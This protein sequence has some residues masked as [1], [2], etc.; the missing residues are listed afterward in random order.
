MSVFQLVPN[1][2]VKD[3]PVSMTTMKTGSTPGSPIPY[4]IIPKT[5]FPGDNNPT[6]GY[7]GHQKLLPPNKMV[8]LGALEPGQVSYLSSAAMAEPL[9]VGCS[10]EDDWDEQ[11][12]YKP[13]P[14]S[15]RGQR[16]NPRGGGG[17][18]GGG[19]GRGGSDPG[20]ASYRRRY[21]G[22]AGGGYGYIQY[23]SSHR[24]RGRERGY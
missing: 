20:R 8:S 9:S 23:N 5:T 14:Q 2:G 10:T 24:G 16:R 15:Q 6:R 12:G 1:P 18:G 21:G 3:V 17:G 7:R 22:D 13:P 4:D 11:P 19:R